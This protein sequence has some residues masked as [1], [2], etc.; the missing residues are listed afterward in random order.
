MFLIKMVSRI[1]FYLSSNRVIL[2]LREAALK[3]IF[4]DHNYSDTNRA[5]L[6]HLSLQPQLEESGCVTPPALLLVEQFSASI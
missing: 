5:H 2:I 1:D 4:T 3:F 6:S